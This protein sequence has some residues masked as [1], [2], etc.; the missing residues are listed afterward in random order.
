MSLIKIA[1]VF[2]VIFAASKF[3]K[4]WIALAI[5]SGALISGFL[6]GHGFLGTLKSFVWGSVSQNSIFL[7]LLVT[8]ISVF[9]GVMEVT[10][11]LENCKKASVSMFSSGRAAGVFMASLIGL[12]PMPGGALFS[13]PLVNSSIDGKNSPGLL[14]ALNYW[15]RHVW[16]FWWPLYPAVITLLAVTGYGMVKWMAHTFIFSAAA[17]L[18]GWIFLYRIVK[19]TKLEKK[20]FR[21]P[22]G[23]FAGFAPLLS[24][25]VFT[26][27]YKIVL[28]VLG[29]E[30]QTELTIIPAVLVGILVC[31]KSWK[32]GMSAGKAVSLS[33]LIPLAVMIITI[34]GY[35]KVIE[36]AGIAQNIAIDIQTLN[37][38]VLAVFAFLPFIAGMITGIAIGF[39]GASFPLIID[40]LGDFPQYSKTAVLILSFGFGYAGMMLSPFHACLLLSKEYFCS[41]WKDTYKYLL[42]PTVTLTA[43]FIVYYLLA[44]FVFHIK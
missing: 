1:I 8:L 33:R 29:I 7:A 21:V 22:K 26:I 5:F 20:P 6:F 9:S 44:V 18:F 30:I 2:C 12:L 36:E 11:T 34:M 39:I 40:M 28:S 25:I 4:K 41:S 16:E 32:K 3:A 24:V 37:F 15:F 27:L 14:T 19:T 38:P 35:K 42:G 10:G 17:I 13:A 43:F 23:A 31:L